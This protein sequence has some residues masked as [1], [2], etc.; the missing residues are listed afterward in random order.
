MKLIYKTNLYLLY[1][2][3]EGESG[4]SG[5]KNFRFLILNVE[6]RILKYSIDYQHPLYITIENEKTDGIL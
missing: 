2:F 4:S 3:K 1:G 5:T 6:R